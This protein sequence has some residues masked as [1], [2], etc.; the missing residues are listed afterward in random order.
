MSAELVLALIVFILTYSLIAVRKVRGHRIPSWA[1]ACLGAVL[2]LVLGVVS[3]KKAWDFIDF[4]VIFQLIGMMLMTAALQYCGLFEI[5]VDVLMKRFNGHRKFL[6]GVMLI[7]ALLSAVTLNDAVVLIIAPIVLRC[8]QKLHAE[9]APY[10]VGVFVA[11]NIGCMATI[12]GSP[13]N[14][15]VAAQS[16][17]S[18][19]LYSA[20]SIPLTIICLGL[21]I[22]FL[23]RH[24]GKRMDSNDS[25][26]E[27]EVFHSRDI[28]RPCL[29]A[30]L[31]V[32]AAAVVLFALSSFIGVKI[33]QI[34]LGAGIVS[35]LIVMFR[36]PSASVFVVKHV[37][38]S[39]L[40]FFIGLFVVTSGVVDSG[41]IDSIAS[42]F[43]MGDGK[44]PTIGGL[45]GYSV[46]LSNLVSNVP[47]VMLIGQLLPLGDTVLWIALAFSASLAGNLTLIGAATNIIVQ[48]EGEKHGVRLDFFKFLKVGVPVTLATVVIA[49]AYLHILEIVL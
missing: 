35:L 47:S 41:L 11:A 46:V 6:I 9:P 32:T 30:V 2:M 20:C 1:A 42:V 4:D 34:A 18:F 49:I 39:I 3:P 27:G 21:S 13:H 37:D 5:V 14:A 17:M 36:T 43:G 33:Y 40:V 19:I 23:T 8:C 24:Y 44:V 10:L 15:L 31:L 26:L 28:D 38:W 29:A 45:V 7:T 16:G 48:N 12:T 25:S 22:W